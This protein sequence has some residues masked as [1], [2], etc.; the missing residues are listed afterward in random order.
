MVD[1][2]FG[3]FGLMLM[4]LVLPI[5]GVLIYLDSPGAIFFSQERVG[6]QGKIFR[7]Y[8]FRSMHP[9]AERAGES[10]WAS[11]DDPRVT[12]V[13]RLLRATHLDEW[14]QVFNILQGDMSLIG[15][16]PERPDYVAELEKITPLYRCRFNVKPGL[17]GWAQVKYGYGDASQD[18]LIKLRYDLYYIRH[19]S[20]TL[21]VVIILKTLIEVIS[22]RGR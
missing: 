8:T 3:L 1:F 17:T 15:P 19:R 18:E 11:N 20:F 16:R 13:G 5:L 14:P 10:V 4:L 6:Y 7:M 9:D 21:D 22:C 2:I 12:R